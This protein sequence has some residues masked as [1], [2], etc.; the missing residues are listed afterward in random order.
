[1]NSNKE[2][3]SQINLTYLETTFGNNR[4]I[5]NKVLSSFLNNTPQLVEDLSLNAVNSKWEDVQMIAHK[6]KSSFNTLGAT[7]IGNILAEIERGACDKK[8]ESI[9]DM[10]NQVKELSQHVFK[11]VQLELNK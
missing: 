8:V 5:I 6:M 9:L 7:S 11:E 2:L 10:V 4:M 3:N 1:M